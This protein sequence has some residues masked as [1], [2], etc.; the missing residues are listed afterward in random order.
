MLRCHFDLPFLLP[1]SPRPSSIIIPEPVTPTSWLPFPGLRETQ[2][3]DLLSCLACNHSS[4]KTHRAPFAHKI[5][6]LTLLCKFL[7]R[8]LSSPRFL[9]LAI[10]AYTQTP[11]ITSEQQFQFITHAAASC[12]LHTCILRLNSSTGHSGPFKSSS[13]LPAAV[14][15]GSLG[16]I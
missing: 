4:Y 9:L 7:P 3:G 16:S 11:A 10:A 12:N 6:F 5:N 8:P 13:V 15:A 14:H 1:P 2:G